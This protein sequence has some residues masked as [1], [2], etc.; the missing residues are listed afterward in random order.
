MSE[1]N[2][3]DIHTHISKILT[4]ASPVIS[5]KIIARVASTYVATKSVVAFL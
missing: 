3:N 5:S 4:I 2:S 1:S